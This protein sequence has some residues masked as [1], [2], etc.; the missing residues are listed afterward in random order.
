MSKITVKNGV[1]VTAK[2][3]EMLA[4]HF[5]RHT[6]SGELVFVASVEG[7]GRLLEVDEDNIPSKETP[8]VAIGGS[9]NGYSLRGLFAGVGKYKEVDVEI[10]V[11]PRE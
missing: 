9:N 10:T 4:G 3:T 11:V 6:T 2:L 1:P 7:A 8:I 5:Y